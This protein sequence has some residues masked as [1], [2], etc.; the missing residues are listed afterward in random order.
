MASLENL[1]EQIETQLL[2]SVPAL[3]GFSIVRQDE[4]EQAAKDRIVVSCA[5][6]E[7]EIFGADGIT[8]AVLRLPV[9]VTIHLVTRSASQMDSLIAA[10]ADAQAAATPA[11]LAIA[12]A[13]FPNGVFIKLADSGA[14]KSGE[15]GRAASRT[16]EFIATLQST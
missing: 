14:T 3:S 1:A 6:R 9:T 10:V 15:N 11:A 5:P 2:S 16:F 12:R 7:T 4:D 8:P 13:T